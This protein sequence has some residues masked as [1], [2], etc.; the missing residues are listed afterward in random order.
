MDALG[1]ET[2]PRSEVNSQYHWANK[3][4]RQ[5]EDG[6]DDGACERCVLDVAVSA[7]GGLRRC[8]V[9]P[10][11]VA[12]HGSSVRFA[13]RAGGDTYEKLKSNVDRLRQ[14]AA[15]DPGPVVL[16]RRDA[17][18]TPEEQESA[19]L[20]RIQPTHPRF[21]CHPQPSRP[22]CV[23][24]AAEL[25]QKRLAELRPPAD[26]TV[27]SLYVGGVPPSVTVKDLFPYFLAYGEVKDI[28]LDSGKLAAIATFHR[29][30]IPPAPFARVWAILQSAP[31]QK[32]FLCGC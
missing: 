27:T 29:R 9:V 26:P 24:A 25:R 8:S 2:A 12:A 11:A 16:P 19:G 13:R 4:K 21:G 23:R 15:L 28:T 20:P 30:F 7:R 32:R 3:R 31:H 5:E 17:P 6:E 1:E 14:Y 22:W 18:L 10:C